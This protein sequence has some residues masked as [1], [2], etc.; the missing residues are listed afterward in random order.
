[1]S[2]APRLEHVANMHIDLAPAIRGGSTP[3]GDTNWTATTGGTIEAVNSDL[4]AKILPG[5]GDYTTVYA[6]AGVIGLDVHMVAQDNARKD[7][8]RFH[9]KGFISI[10]AEIG[11]F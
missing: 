5:G 6:S 8:F 7:I 10:D 1:M 3:R 9:N 4:Q 11:K 2:P